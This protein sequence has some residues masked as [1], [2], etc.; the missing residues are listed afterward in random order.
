V[1]IDRSLPLSISVRRS[2]ALES[3]LPQPGGSFSF[4]P[5]PAVSYVSWTDNGS[6]ARKYRR[7]VVFCRQGRPPFSLPGCKQF[8]G[9]GRTFP[10]PNLGVQRHSRRGTSVLDF[11]PLPTLV[12]CCPIVG[13]PVVSLFLFHAETW[14]R[15]PSVHPASSFFGHRP[16]TV[17]MWL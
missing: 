8:C 16:R 1:F 6:V 11:F 12:K 4:S 17:D 7:R 14:S 15:D 13:R 5:P 10:S 3:H 2:L 9:I